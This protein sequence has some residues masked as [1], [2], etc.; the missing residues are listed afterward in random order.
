MRIVLSKALNIY[1]ASL[2]ELIGFLQFIQSS[3]GSGADPNAYIEN[4]DD[5]LIFT[6][7]VSSLVVAL[8]GA[9]IYDSVQFSF[10]V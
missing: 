10:S 2:I 7:S 3:G 6:H 5:E 8:L 9:S 1:W 4:S